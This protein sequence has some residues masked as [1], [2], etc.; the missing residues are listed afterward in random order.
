MSVDDI[1][2]ALVEL[3]EFCGNH[4]CYDCPFRRVDS[5]CRLNR[6]PLNWAIDDWEDEQV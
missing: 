5:V 3:K 2:K 6:D 1:K 4:R